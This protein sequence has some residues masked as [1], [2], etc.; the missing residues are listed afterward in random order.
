MKVV[1]LLTLV[2]IGVGAGSVR[3][4]Q[5]TP[6]ERVQS[7]A[8]TGKVGQARSALLA[9][10]DSG[11][12]SAGREDRQR[13]LWLRGRLT[14]DPRQ[15]AMDFQRLVVEYPGGPFTD[16]A[17]FRLAQEA[18]ASGDS[19][20]A[21]QRVA[22]LASDYP[23]S[24]TRQRAEKWLQTVG[25]PPP[26]IPAAVEDSVRAADSL[27]AVAARARAEAKKKEEAA[28]ARAERARYAIQLGA[29]GGVARAKILAERVRKAG[30]DVRLVRVRGS[31]LIRVRT[32]RFDS[33]SSA[34][35]LLKRVEKLG[36]KALVV[37]D[38]RQEERVR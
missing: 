9:W 23:N 17:L 16:R 27:R 28:K 34:R 25:P 14:S 1:T 2:M 38:A 8:S 12:S 36:F 21:R 10:W 18:F 11:W 22:D 7:L 13:A 32:G 3:G 30:F 31:R 37:H 26:P 20:A 19:V 5:Q 24:S 33:S 6:L 29:F 4:Q 15:A 35:D